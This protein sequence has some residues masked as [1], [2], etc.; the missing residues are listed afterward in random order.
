[1]VAFSLDHTNLKNS[2]NAFRIRYT[3]SQKG[4]VNTPI[5][6]YIAALFGVGKVSAH[7]NK[8]NYELRIEGHKNVCTVFPYFDSFPLRSKKS[9]SYFNWRYVHKGIGDK[10][11]LTAQ[12]RA[13]LT[14]LAAK[15]N[16]TD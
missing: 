9:K 6:N 14:A 7:S 10:L 1:V 12:G 16:N 5:L 3:L 4:V 15:I 13:N 8:G 2:S 11:H